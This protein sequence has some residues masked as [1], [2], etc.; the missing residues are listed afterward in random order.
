MHSRWEVDWLP[1]LIL[2]TASSTAQV[3][4]PHLRLFIAKLLTY[5]ESLQVLPREVVI[6]WDTASVHILL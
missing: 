6:D 1:L 3:R 2:D 4:S 5:F